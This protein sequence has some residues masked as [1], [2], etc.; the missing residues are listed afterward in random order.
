MNK[1]FITVQ[2][3]NAEKTLR[4]AIDSIL[5]QTYKNFEI[6][7]CDDA[8]EDSTPD[9]IREYEKKGLIKAFFNDTN[10]V[11]SDGGNEF[12]D[13]K[14]HISDDDF[15]AQLDA[16]DELYPEFFEKLLNFAVENDLDI[17]EASRTINTDGVISVGEAQAMLK[18]N[19]V[20]ETPE[21]FDK[22][23][24]LLYNYSGTIWGKLFRGN[25]SGELKYT[26]A[27]FGYAHDTASVL[28]AVK[29][30]R[31]VGLFHEPLVMYYSSTSSVSHRYDE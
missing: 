30:A 24:C 8:S 9:I 29:K 19:I 2:A 20:L 17:A 3:Y 23:F 28:S 16:D 22:H 18:N 10:G 14:N 1:I 6:F 15:Y 31:R 11:Y 5:A 4:R 25:V 21:D 27:N 26:L 13:V 7:V 12:L